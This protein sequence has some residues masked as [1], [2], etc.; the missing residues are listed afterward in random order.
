M[1]RKR[2]LNMQDFADWGVFEPRKG[3]EREKKLLLC[4]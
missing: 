1:V 2:L 4:Q 3:V